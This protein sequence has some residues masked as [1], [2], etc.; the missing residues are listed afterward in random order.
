M[1]LS[2][3]IGYCRAFQVKGLGTAISLN[4]LSTSHI[5]QV[6]GQ[7]NNL[8]TCHATN[9]R[10]TNRHQGSPPQP[11]LK[12][13]LSH[14][15]FTDKG[16]ADQESREESQNSTHRKG[17]IL[18]RISPSKHVCYP[19]SRKGFHRD[20]VYDWG[21]PGRPEEEV[22]LQLRSPGTTTGHV[23]T[24]HETSGHHQQVC[25]FNLHVRRLFQIRKVQA[26][27]E[28]RGKGF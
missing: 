17:T 26:S 4:P 25:A 16:D 7:A 3:E 13:H 21:P 14:C 18:P 27:R 5:L 20:S 28:V 1:P 24:L 10:R 12:Q 2:G 15:L 19:V 9:E 23:P 6:K 11:F 8:Q 22:G